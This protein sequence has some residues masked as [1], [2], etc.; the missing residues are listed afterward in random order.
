MSYFKDGYDIINNIILK[1]K[2]QKREVKNLIDN[3]ISAIETETI[4][5]YFY[6]DYQKLNKLIVKVKWKDKDKENKEKYLKIREFYKEKNR[7]TTILL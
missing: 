1:E 7:N 6:S 4:D 3:M 5:E 2:K